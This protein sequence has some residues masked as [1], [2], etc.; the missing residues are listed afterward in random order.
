MLASFYFSFSFL[1]S[2]LFP[3]SSLHYPLYLRKS[4]RFRN[5]FPPRNRFQAGVE[6]GRNL[7]QAYG[8]YSSP[9]FS[10]SFLSFSILFSSSMKAFMGPRCIETNSFFNLFLISGP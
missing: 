4:N 10:F 2:F 7:N 9:F 3:F 8:S 1:P 6:C 5:R